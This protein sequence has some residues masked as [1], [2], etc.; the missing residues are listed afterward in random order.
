MLTQSSGA[1]IALREGDVM[2]CRARAG[3]TAPDLGAP[4][5]T[6]SGLSGECVRS[7]LTLVCD[8]TENDARVN[9][10][11]CRYLGIRSIAVLPISVEDET[12]GVFEAF[13]SRAR[14]FSSNELSALESM[15]DLVISVIRPAPQSQNA[16]ASALAAR[17]AQERPAPSPLAPLFDPEDDLICELEQRL[18]APPPVDPVRRAFELIKTGNEEAGAPPAAAPFVN[19]DP[20]DDLICEIATRSYGSPAAAAEPEHAHPFSTFAP[21]AAHPS[22]RPVSRKLIILG[23]L[24]ALAGLIWLHWCSR[25]QPGPANL[26]RAGA[27]ALP[28]LQMP[29]PSPQAGRVAVALVAGGRAG[30]AA[31]AVEHYRHPRRLP[32]GG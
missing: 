23:I 25:A 18:P 31:T 7:G 21:A 1:A 22:E 11:V 19:P 26:P 29:R 28:P 5:D 10:D 14:A 27:Q 3:A 24:V 8:D 9:L 30:L 13:S 12:V 15:R 2:R 17:A 4:L 6:Q 16:A 20:A 32:R